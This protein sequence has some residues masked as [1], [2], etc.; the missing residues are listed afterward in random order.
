MRCLRLILF[1]CVDE[2]GFQNLAVF[3]FG[4]FF[5]KL[6]ALHFF[7]CFKKNL[8]SLN[9]CLKKKDLDGHVRMTNKVGLKGD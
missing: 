8:A 3:G 4:L 7:L 6:I 2:F 5:L 1:I 9:T